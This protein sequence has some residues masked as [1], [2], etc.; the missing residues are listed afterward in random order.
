MVDYQLRVQADTDRSGRLEGDEIC[1]LLMGF[2]QRAGVS[3]R[4]VKV[5]EAVDEYMV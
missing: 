4:P 1:Q 2:Y 3:R 5:Q